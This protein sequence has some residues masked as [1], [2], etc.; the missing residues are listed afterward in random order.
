[1]IQ[2]GTAGKSLHTV[3][4]IYVH[5]FRSIC[6]YLQDIF[7]I[8]CADDSLGLRAMKNVAIVVRGTYVFT[9]NLVHVQSIH[10]KMTITS[11]KQRWR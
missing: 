9:G 4:Q 1:M 2:E 5:V 7:E 8:A 11:G 3:C 6:L 10:C